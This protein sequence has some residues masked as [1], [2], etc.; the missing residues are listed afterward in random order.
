M[1]PA[2]RPASCGADS[3]G[4]AALA[5]PPESLLLRFLFADGTG[6]ANPVDGRIPG[7]GGAPATGPPESDFFSTTGA[8]L[9]FVTTDFSLFPLLMSDR[10]APWPKL[11]AYLTLVIAL[12]HK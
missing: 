1:P 12:A 7:I 4:G 8:D 10:S 2:K 6:G 5:A 3:I 11:S 9:S